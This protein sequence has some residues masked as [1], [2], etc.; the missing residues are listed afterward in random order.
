MQNLSNI[1]DLLSESIAQGNNGN[2]FVEINDAIYLAYP[3][4]TAMAEDLRHRIQRGNLSRIDVV[5]RF[6]LP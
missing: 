4:P 5:T 1:Q 3:S 6:E 2:C